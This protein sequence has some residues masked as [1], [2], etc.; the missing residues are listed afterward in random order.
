MKIFLIFF[1]NIL[2]PNCFM[3]FLNKYLIDIRLNMLNIDLD[4]QIDYHKTI[5]PSKAVILKEKY[6]FIFPHLV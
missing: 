3:G 6:Y 2:T 1:I 5:L 4:T